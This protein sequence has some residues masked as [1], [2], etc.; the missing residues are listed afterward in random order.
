MGVF[1]PK[2]GVGIRNRLPDPFV[3]KRVKKGKKGTIYWDFTKNWNF[4]QNLDFFQKFQILPFFY[5]F[6]PFFG[7]G[8]KVTH[9]VFLP[10]KYHVNRPNRKKLWEVEIWVTRNDKFCT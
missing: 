8:Q 10:H 1:R 2:N 6:Y 3:S 9:F 5:P 4:F 7:G